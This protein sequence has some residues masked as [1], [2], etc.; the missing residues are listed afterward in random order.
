M[1]ILTQE[2][3]SFDHYCGTLRGVRGFADRQVLKYQDGTTIFDQPDK[4]RA[5]LGHR[6]PFHM[7]STK[8]DAQNAG[9]L[10]HS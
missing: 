10:D 8:V 4:S 6:L 3:R 2:N 7:D 5:D 9:D 1:L